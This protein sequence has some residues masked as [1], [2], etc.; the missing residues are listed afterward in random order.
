MQHII[1]VDIWQRLKVIPWNFRS[2]SDGGTQ[3][4]C[5]TPSRRFIKDISD[6]SI[7]LPSSPQTTPGALST[8]TSSASAR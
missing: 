1:V 3:E 5:Y 4:V 2:H 6:I 8:A 7:G